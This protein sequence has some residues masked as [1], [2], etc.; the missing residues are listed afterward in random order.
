ML[1]YMDIV[2]LHPEFE[3]RH[4]K[5]VAVLVQGA[6]KILDVSTN[7][8]ACHAEELALWRYRNKFR[9][10]TR[11][12]KL[13]VVRISD[14]D[15]FSRPCRDCCS[16]MLKYPHI[17]VFYSDRDGNWKEEV[18]YDSVH[19][20]RRRAHLNAARYCPLCRTPV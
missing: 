18:D 8:Y 7:R 15:K 5:H 16:L 3:L 1:S 11:H 19:I 10:C 14:T 9:H 4:A 20:S 6:N 12:I 13:F 2:Q 17:R